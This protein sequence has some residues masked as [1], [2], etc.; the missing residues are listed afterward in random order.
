MSRYFY[1]NSDTRS[2]RKNHPIPDQRDKRD[3]S[4]F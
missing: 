2:Q 3:I 1:A 4:V